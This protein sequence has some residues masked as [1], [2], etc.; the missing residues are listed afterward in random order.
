MNPI[1]PVKTRLAS[2][3][4]RY[5][6]RRRT[7]SGAPLFF[8]A[9]LTAGCG[10]LLLA[11]A[12]IPVA[13]ATPTVELGSAS[14]APGSTV[15]L[16]L[17]IR[18]GATNVIAA[19][20]D[21][22]YASTNLSA[23]AAVLDDAVSNLT[24]ASSAVRPG[25]Q[26]LIV[27]SRSGSPLPD[28]A[29]FHIPVAVSDGAVSAAIPVSLEHVILAD[30]AARAVPTGPLTAGMISVSTAGGAHFQSVVLSSDGIL[31]LQLVGSAGNSYVLQTSPDLRA[32]LPVS[33]NAAAGG[34]VILTDRVKSR[35]LFYRAVLVP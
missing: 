26:R 27:Y 1:P 11:S 10:L 20:L 19:Q 25:V 33:T 2:G 23:Q 35:Q 29:R 9:R 5:F 30:G 28:P 17:I 34:V 13:R 4:A 8:G 3:P 31:H 24:V 32:W 15:L 22:R 7:T 16:P 6:A 12:L 21:V 18:G 14:G